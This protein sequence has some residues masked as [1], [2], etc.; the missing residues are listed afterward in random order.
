MENITKEPVT[1][2][3]ILTILGIIIIPLIIWGVSIERRF[4]IVIQ[5]TK[6]I[7]SV[8]TRMGDL[9]TAD[10]ENIK[11]IEENY[12]QLYD[13]LVDIRLELKDKLNRNE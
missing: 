4:E 7:Q 8:K 1:F 3:N 2:G 10:K 9:E 5:N 13:I 11:K 12:K 6:E